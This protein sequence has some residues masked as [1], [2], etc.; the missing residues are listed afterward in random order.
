MGKRPGYFLQEPGG[1]PVGMAGGAFA[2]FDPVG[3]K[4]KQWQIQTLHAQHVSALKTA[5][6]KILEARQASKTS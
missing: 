3:Q 5:T 1:V 2:N 6:R 4:G